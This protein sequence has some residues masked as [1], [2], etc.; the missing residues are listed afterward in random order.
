MS[1]FDFDLLKIS[2]LYLEESK[3]RCRVVFV[4]GSND[5]ID[6]CVVAGVAEP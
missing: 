6:L 1:T 3:G 4:D 2:H 5:G